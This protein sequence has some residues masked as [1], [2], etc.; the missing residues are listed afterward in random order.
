MFEPSATPGLAPVEVTEL[1][2]SEFMVQTSPLVL[3]T[4]NPVWRRASVSQDISTGDREKIWKFVR[5]FTHRR[6]NSLRSNEL[7]I[8]RKKNGSDSP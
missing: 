4:I 8:T 1:P 6:T 2:H 5:M 7:S 3:R